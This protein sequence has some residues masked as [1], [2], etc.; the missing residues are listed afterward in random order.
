MLYRLL[1]IFPILRAIYEYHASK[2]LPLLFMNYLSH[3]LYFC[4][5]K[6][7]VQQV[8][9]P[10]MQTTGNRKEPSLVSKTH[11]VEFPSRVF[12]VC[13]ESVLP[14]VID[15]THVDDIRE[16]CRVKSLY[17]KLHWYTICCLKFEFHTCTSS[18]YL[19]F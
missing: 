5:N 8:C 9:D 2:N 6:S 17:L 1:Y 11:R 16:C 12:P 10:L 7:T 14:Y 4:M 15:L 13:R 3:F 18:N 19:I